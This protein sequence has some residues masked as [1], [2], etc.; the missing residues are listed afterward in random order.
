MQSS[1]ENT[2]ALITSEISET[3]SK[4][5][6]MFRIFSRVKSES[7]IRHKLEVKFLNS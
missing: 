4:C 1:L 7:S 2:A 6:L 3:L 5:G